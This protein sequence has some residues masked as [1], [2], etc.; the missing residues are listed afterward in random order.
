LRVPIVIHWKFETPVQT[1]VIIII[2]IMDISKLKVTRLTLHLSETCQYFQLRILIE[3]V[4]SNVYYVFEL[5]IGLLCAFRVLL[6]YG[7]GTSK[8]E[9]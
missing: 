8:M 9:V 6:N 4:K 3:F 5:V 2:T 7:I 1:N